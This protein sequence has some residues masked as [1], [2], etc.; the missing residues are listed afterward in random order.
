MA[1]INGFTQN[2][3]SGVTKG[4]NSPGK[5]VDGI[6]SYAAVDNPFKF[7]PKSDDFKSRIRFYDRDSLWARWRRGYELYTITQSVLGSYAAERG[8]YGDY[9]MYCAYQLFPGIYIPARVFTFPTATDEINEQI[10]G[11]RDANGFNFYNF[12]LSILA[13]RYLK[14]VKSGTYTQTATTLT[15]AATNHG[16]S[17]GDTVTLVITSGAASTATLTIATATT[18]VFTCTITGGEITTGTVD[19]KTA[20]TFSDLNWNET[21]VKLRSIF[22]P[23]PFLLGERLVDR[24][25]EKDPGVASTYSRTGTTVTV[26]CVSPHGLATGNTVFADVTSGTVTSKQYIVTVTSTT[27]LQFTTSSSGSTSGDLVINR[28]ISGYDYKDYAGYTLNGIDYTTTEL[29]FQR[30]DSY[31]AKTTDNKTK[32]IAPAYRGFAVGR[33]LTTEIR[34]QCTCPDYTR[35]SGYNLFKENTNDKFPNTAITSVKPGQKVNKDNSISDVRDEPGTFGDLGYIATVSNFYDTPN[36]NDTSATSYNNLKYYQLRWCKHIYAALFSINHDEG[37]T[38]VLGSGTYQQAGANV[39]ITIENHG[40]NANSKIQIDFTSGSAISGEY[41]ITEVVN[42]NTFK[43]VYPFS[44]TTNGYCSVTNVKRHQFINQWLLE[45]SDK[46]IGDDLDTFYRNFNKENNRLRQAA[47]RLSMM[48]QGM[49]WVGSLQV[50]SASTQPTQTANYDTQ[51]VSMMLSDNI[52]R[53]DTGNLNRSVNRAGVL[54]NSTQR[55][56]AMMSKLIN[57]EPSQILGE[58]FGM[59]DQPLD[60]YDTTYQFGLL[61]NGVY[62]NGLPFSTPGARTSAFAFLNATYVQ[63]NAD[64]VVTTSVFHNLQIE[65]YVYLDVLTG[66]AVDAVLQIIAVT[67]KSFTVVSTTTFT[68][69]SGTVNC[70]PPTEDPATVTVL[71]CLTYDPSI[72]QEFTLDAGT[73]S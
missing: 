60:D 28:L 42:V 11:I 21:R 31:S 51:L 59:L 41:T 64:I 55:M 73:Y 13:V 29:I 67:A 15:V 62:L 68:N 69:A 16:Y 61:D 6:D 54:Q 30:K 37:N 34:Y 71:D 7:T 38:P 22:P 24:V 23:I 63:T 32:T 57:V 33:F 3:S 17:V 8:V 44:S 52:R 19:I 26:N 40:L 20:T 12:G 46:P 35:R 1:R 25:V 45:P 58:N 36:Y 70:Y 65:D 39:V 9:R 4:F 27:Q 5:P 49:K 53:D 48:K 10:V 66:T 18:D 47:E 14:T 43:I 56:S 72:P 2:F 50:A